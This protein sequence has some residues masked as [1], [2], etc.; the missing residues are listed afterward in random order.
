MDKE[1]ATLTL[2]SNM[3]SSVGVPE[4]QFKNIPIK[5]ILGDMWD[6]YE[7]FN[8]VLNCQAGVY[9]SAALNKQYVLRI[10]GLDWVDITQ[11]NKT[12]K[13]SYTPAIILPTVTANSSNLNQMPANTGFTFRRPTNT[14]IDLTIA[15]LDRNITVP[16]HNIGS[17]MHVFSI[18]GV[19]DDFDD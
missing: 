7:K 14:M 5:Q 2:H 9:I 10:Q 18:Y 1:C 3:V 11:Y 15:Y 4:L 13:Y 12:T 17:T 8:L 6:K 19:D 16:T